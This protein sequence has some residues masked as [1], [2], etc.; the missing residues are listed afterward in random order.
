MRAHGVSSTAPSRPP[1]ATATA[2][3]QQ[4]SCHCQLS[5]GVRQRRVHRPGAALP[6]RAAWRE[7]RGGGPAEKVRASGPGTALLGQ[8]G[9]CC[10]AH[11]T[12]ACILLPVGLAKDV[13]CN[14]AAA[15]SWLAWSSAMAA[16]SAVGACVT[17]RCRHHR[18]PGHPALDAR[19]HAACRLGRCAGVLSADRALADILGEVAQQTAALQDRVEGMGSGGGAVPAVSPPGAVASPDP[20]APDEYVA[21]AAAACIPLHPCFIVSACPVFINDV[22][23]FSGS[24][25]TAGCQ[26][27]DSRLLPLLLTLMVSACLLLRIWRHCWIPRQTRP[28]CPC[29]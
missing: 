7:G 22:L 17:D 29:C 20:V 4:G 24:E 15:A 10:A 9:W 11:G 19:L 18:L 3:L 5:T 13:A 1:P 27:T 2:P 26:G 16:D 8:S 28:T 23:C 14:R 21:R 25:G 6:E 12:R